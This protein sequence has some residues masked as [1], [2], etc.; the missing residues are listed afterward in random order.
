MN[1]R[2]LEVEKEC[3]FAKSL[4][5]EGIGEGIVWKAAL[6]LGA[7]AKFWL[8]T[9]GP[10]HQHSRVDKL[11]A[12]GLSGHAFAKARQFAEAAVSERRCEQ[13]WEYLEEMGLEKNKKNVKVVVEWMCKDVEVE[14]RVGI[15]E[16]EVDV[17]LLRKAIGACVRSWYFGKMGVR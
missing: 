2:T 5:V 6:P 15:E 8:K 10:E 7:D 4:G 3:P 13:A 17:K 14:E 16:L 1:A 11:E 12:L 9:K